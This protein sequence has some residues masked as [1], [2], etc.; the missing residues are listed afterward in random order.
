MNR[1]I[2]N[3][4]SKPFNNVLSHEG[5]LITKINI[6]KTKFEII[7]VGNRLLILSFIK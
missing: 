7:C 4:Y 1:L 5:I 3:R 2:D 6:I